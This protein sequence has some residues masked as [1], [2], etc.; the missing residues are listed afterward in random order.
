M[1]RILALLTHMSVVLVLI[2]SPAMNGAT[3]T[4][5]PKLVCG[6]HHILHGGPPCATL[7]DWVTA[8]ALLVVTLLVLSM[9]F[10]LPLLKRWFRQRGEGS[11]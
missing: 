4:I 7:E 9:A 1:N 10:G 2:V 6:S 3:D 11:L 5:F 8:A